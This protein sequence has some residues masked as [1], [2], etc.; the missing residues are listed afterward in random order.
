MKKE[1]N[2]YV[3]LPKYDGNIKTIFG[4]DYYQKWLLFGKLKHEY[5][6]YTLKRI[7]DFDK[8]FYDKELDMMFID[9]AARA[10]WIREDKEWKNLRKKRKIEK[11]NFKKAKFTRKTKVLKSFQDLKNIKNKK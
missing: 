7:V 5:C 11:K 3:S 9:H 8:A 4:P 6:P 10:S 1:D 2:P